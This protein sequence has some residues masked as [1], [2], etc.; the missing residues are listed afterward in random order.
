MLLAAVGDT[1][2]CYIVVLVIQKNIGKYLKKDRMEQ[3]QIML[4]LFSTGNWLNCL[5]NSCFKSTV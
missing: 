2:R 4:N 3:S 1:C 5:L